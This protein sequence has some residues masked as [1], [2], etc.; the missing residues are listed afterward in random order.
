MDDFRT[1]PIDELI[2]RGSQ[3]VPEVTQVLAYSLVESELGW[4]SRPEHGRTP[5]ARVQAGR[6]SAEP[7]A[8]MAA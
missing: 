6:R 3:E 5:H 4:R 2:A 7:N 1:F 8:K